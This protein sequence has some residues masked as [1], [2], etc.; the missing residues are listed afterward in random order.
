VGRYWTVEILAATRSPRGPRKPALGA[1]HPRPG[2]ALRTADRMGTTRPA[3]HGRAWPFVAPVA[4]RRDHRVL[5]RHV[6]S[7]PRRWIRVA[8]WGGAPGRVRTVGVVPTALAGAADWGET[9]E[10]ERRI[11][12]L[13]GLGIDAGMFLFAGSLVARLRGGHRVGT[14]L[15][16]AGNLVIAGA[17]FLGGRLALHHGTARRTS[18]DEQN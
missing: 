6:P 9:S 14:Q 8:P 13:H 16:V 4:D 7:R 11:G 3:T 15:A 12:A 17:G 1:D 18:M 2:V 10:V 5:A